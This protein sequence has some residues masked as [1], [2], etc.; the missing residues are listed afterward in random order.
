M[1]SKHLLNER[2]WFHRIKFPR[3]QS[4]GGGGWGQADSARRILI[5]EG[6]RPT[7]SQLF[8]EKMSLQEN[9]KLWNVL[10]VWIFVIKTRNREPDLGSNLKD[11][12]KRKWKRR[13]RVYVSLGLFQ[14]SLKMFSSLRHF[15]CFFFP[16]ALDLLA[17]PPCFQSSTAQHLV[18]YLFFST[19]S[20][21]LP[22][23]T[24]WWYTHSDPLH[25]CPWHRWATQ[26]WFINWFLY[27]LFDFVIKC[28]NQ[29]PIF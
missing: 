18:C 24:G 16:S 25:P 29:I 21:F 14:R 28:Q 1:F 27:W 23:E 4:K 26:Q 12:G 5:T 2:P 20:W 19:C 17:T 3:R 7:K 22:Q 9:V 8:T 6:C 10:W 15:S 13:H 11:K